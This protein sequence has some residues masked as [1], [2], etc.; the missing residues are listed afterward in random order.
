MNEP[1]SPAESGAR[2]TRVEAI[3]RQFGFVGTVKYRHVST[4]SGGAQYREGATIE[5][6][7]LATDLRSDLEKNL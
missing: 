4:R 2:L 7:V 3:A 5:Q 6:D 1:I